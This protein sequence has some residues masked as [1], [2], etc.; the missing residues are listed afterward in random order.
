MT[1]SVTVQ[2]PSTGTV[3][4]SG[5]VVKTPFYSFETRDDLVAAVFDG[6]RW[7]DGTKL[8]AGNFEYRVDR[9]TLDLLPGLPHMRPH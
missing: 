1:L 9:D 7:P 4:P 6:M 5:T 3:V 8:P 2:D